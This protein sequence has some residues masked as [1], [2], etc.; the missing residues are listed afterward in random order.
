MHATQTVPASCQR[1]IIEF[2]LP[3]TTIV[4]RSLPSTLPTINHGAVLALRG[5]PFVLVGCAPP[6]ELPS[7]AS[8]RMRCGLRRWQSSM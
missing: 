8:S 1:A 5:R 2:P 7:V 6:S 3:E 4:R